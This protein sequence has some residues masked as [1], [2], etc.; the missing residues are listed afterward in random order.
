M[1]ND[2]SPPVKRIDSKPGQPNIVLILVD[3]LGWMDL[4][5][6]GSELFE[7]PHLDRLATEGMR[8][9]DAYAACA[10]CSPTR[11]AVQ[12]GRHPA[13][14]FVTD[15]IRSR[16]QGGNIPA[17]KINPCLVPK[18]KWR[19]KGVM[20][21]PNA[22]WMESDELTIAEALKP[23]GY[24]SCYIGKW[25]L[26]TDPWYPTQQGFDFNFGGCDYGQP[27]NYFDPFNQPKGRH[28][29]LRDGIPGLPSRQTGQYL[30]DREADEAVQFIRRNRSKPFFL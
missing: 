19:G 21:P 6:Q 17:D 11:A 26:G 18:E 7:T 27:P 13:R 20:C 3:D 8:F 29:M 28:E 4:G 14:L 16:F 24:T 25:H 23:A 12:T 5:C 1:A 10:V 2:L 22:L 9:T 15:W 30:S